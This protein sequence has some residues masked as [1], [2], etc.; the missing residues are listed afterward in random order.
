MKSSPIP[1]NQSSFEILHLFDI[2]HYQGLV[3]LFFS[4]DAILIY[5]ETDDVSII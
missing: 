2:W 3:K 4:A 1:G 5:D